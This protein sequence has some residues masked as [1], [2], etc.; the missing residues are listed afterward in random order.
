MIHA[1]AGVAVIGELAEQIDVEHPLRKMS[2]TVG[3]VERMP[4]AA[5]FWS[6][7]MHESPFNQKE[8]HV[9]QKCAR[10]GAGRIRGD[11]L[12]DGGRVGG[13]SSI[14]GGVE[15]VRV[16]NALVRTHP[17][18]TS[19][20]ES[21]SSRCSGRSLRSGR[22]VPNAFGNGRVQNSLRPAAGIGSASLTSPLRKL[23]TSSVKIWRPFVACPSPND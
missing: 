11:R 6:R 1:S 14:D 15:N 23:P 13:P 7:C 2:R 10:I 3:T 4:V 22:A 21:T 19:A 16:G 18:S 17:R 8:R 12:D 9:I 20:P 5:V